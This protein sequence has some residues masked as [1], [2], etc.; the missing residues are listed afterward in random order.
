M[1]AAKRKRRREPAF[2][3]R[4]R[5]APGPQGPG[6]FF[7]SAYA[8]AFLMIGAHLSI[9][10][11]RC[12]CSAAGVCWLGGYVTAPRSVNF[13]RRAVSASASCI[14]FTS[15]SITGLGV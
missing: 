5:F 7:Q 8:P 3:L 2:L 4:E 10:A 13:C 15:L 11:L 6:A 12:A 9:S 14:A 1:V